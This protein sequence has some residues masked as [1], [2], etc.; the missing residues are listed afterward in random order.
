MLGDNIIALRKKMGLSQQELA[1]RIHVVRQTVSKWEKNLSVPD[2]AALV[3]L[4]DALDVTTAVLLGEKA[5]EKDAQPDIAA[6]LSRI[7]DQLAAQNRHRNRV[8]KAIAWIAAGLAALY[9]LLLALGW[10]Q[11]FASFEEHLA[12]PLDEQTV[13]ITQ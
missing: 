4:A 10:A 11:T 8:W 6:A 13:E 9:L 5:P 1:D 7:N 3:A 2:A 12:V